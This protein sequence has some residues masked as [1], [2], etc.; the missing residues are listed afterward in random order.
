[1]FGQKVW[2]P[3]AVAVVMSAAAFLPQGVAVAATPGTIDTVTC[4]Q[5]SAELRNGSLNCSPLRHEGRD[6]VFIGPVTSGSGSSPAGGT[7]SG[8]ATSS[9]GSGSTGGSTTTPPTTDPT[10]TSPTT[11][12]TRPTTQPPSGGSDDDDNSGSGGGSDDD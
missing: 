8:S 2:R 5:L 6:G 3:V 4:S 11:Q 12:P 1:M 9:G 10:T 7:A